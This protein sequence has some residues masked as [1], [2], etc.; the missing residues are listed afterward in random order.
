MEM[1]QQMAELNTEMKRV[2]V[3]AATQ[4]NSQ[5]AMIRDMIEYYFR[6]VLAGTSQVVDRSSRGR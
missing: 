2:S 6:K 4:L 5:Y 3:V 1:G